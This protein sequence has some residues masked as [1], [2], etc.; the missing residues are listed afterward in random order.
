[1]PLGVW[2]SGLLSGVAAVLLTVCELLSGYNGYF[3]RSWEFRQKKQG[4]QKMLPYTISS[5]FYFRGKGLIM[6][7]FRSDFVSFSMVMS[8]QGFAIAIYNAVFR[9]FSIWTSFNEFSSVIFGLFSVLGCRL[10]V[11][12]GCW[13]RQVASSCEKVE[14]YIH[15]LFSVFWA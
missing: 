9:C 8:L 14:L 11:G 3:L 1:M 2:G 5:H 15:I 10:A 13:V 12:G 6:G 4:F 7:W